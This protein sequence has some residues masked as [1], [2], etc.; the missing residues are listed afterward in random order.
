MWPASWSFWRSTSHYPMM[1]L[2]RLILFVLQ[3]HSW[4]RFCTRFSS[5]IFP[6]L[7]DLS[8]KEMVCSPARWPRQIQSLAFV[9]SRSTSHF[10]DLQTCT[11]IRNITRGGFSIAGSSARILGLGGRQP[12]ELNN[13]KPRD[14]LNDLFPGDS[15]EHFNGKSCLKKKMNPQENGIKTEPKQYKQLFHLIYTSLCN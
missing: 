15:R 7:S 5:E 9:L 1:R 2:W 3:W 6:G 10:R 4:I 14:L 13:F 11:E 8:S 12:A